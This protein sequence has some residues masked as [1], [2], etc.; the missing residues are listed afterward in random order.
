MVRAF[1]S[2]AQL[3]EVAKLVPLGRWVMAG[4]VAEAILFFAS[5]AAAMCT[6]TTLDVDGGMMVS[7][8]QPYEEY[9][10]RRRAARPGS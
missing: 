3:A 2:E 1:N 7:N 9:F 10:A 4:D 6:G 5:P 8:G